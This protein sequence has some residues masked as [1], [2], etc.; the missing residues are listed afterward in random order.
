[1]ESSMNIETNMHENNQTMGTTIGR[2][3]NMKHEIM[4]F[5]RGVCR[6]NSHL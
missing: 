5:T 3:S 2:L 6:N 1:M 4:H